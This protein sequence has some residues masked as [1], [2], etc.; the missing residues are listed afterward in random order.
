MSLPKKFEL[1]GHTITVKVVANL[2]ESGIVGRWTASKNLIEV[3]KV[4]KDMT[5]SFQMQTFW[6]EVMHATLEVQG[7][8]KHSKNEKLVDRMGQALHQVTRTME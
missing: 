8:E 6:H 1:G 4:N 5:E 3:Q 7:Y 2:L